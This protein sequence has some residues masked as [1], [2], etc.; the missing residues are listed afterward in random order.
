[1]QELFTYLVANA[2]ASLHQVTN[3]EVT[4][5]CAAFPCLK[6][7]KTTLHRAS[8]LFSIIDESTLATQV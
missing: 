3:L 2:S 5:K 7:V 6:L 8:F 1:M 4:G